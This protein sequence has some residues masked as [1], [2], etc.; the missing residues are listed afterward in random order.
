MRQG[1]G[2]M[3]IVLALTLTLALTG[4]ALAEARGVTKDTIKI[5]LVLVK[6]GPVAALG[7]PNGQGMVDYFKYINE[8]G[9][10]N[11]RKVEVIWEDDQ[12]EAP[13]SVAAVKKLMTRDEVLTIMTTG[14]TTQTIANLGNI[15]NYKITNI[16]NALAREFYDPLNPYIFAMGATYEAQYY[17][18]VDYIND[19]LGQADPKIGVVYTKKEY[20]KV[21]LEAIKARAAKYNIPVVA[22]VVMPTG[23]VDASSQV[24]ALQKAGA[25]IVITCDVL[26][27]VI[28]FVQT[29]AKYNYKPY[30]FGF[31]WACDDMIV[32]ACGEAAEKYLAVNFVG[33][34]S[35]EAPE[36]KLARDLAA[37]YDAKPG[38]TSLYLNGMGVAHLFAEAIKRA[39]DDLNPDTL[40]AAMETL[41]AYD[42]GG[43]FPPVTYTDKSHA[44]SEMIKVFKADVP[45]KRLVAVTDWRKPK[46]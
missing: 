4:L 30:I 13:K 33:G 44:P 5:G 18:I 32:Q 17:C 15:A 22:E 29:T 8:Q 39:G 21:G 16:P 7:L 3:T 31:N 28:S 20:G 45:N 10:I 34:W 36:I 24:L 26:P 27:P 1:K 9:G 25:N 14:G 40:K 12:F 41:D 23:A 43:L 38:L 42:T 6:T 46:E 19:D 2:W 11:G 35:D 37:K